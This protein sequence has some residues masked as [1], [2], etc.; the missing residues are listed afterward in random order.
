MSNERL[1]DLLVFGATGF[2]G[3]LTAEYLTRHVGDDIRWAIAGRDEHRLAHIKQE[4]VALN[5]AC[6]AVGIIVADAHDQ[7]S[8][9]EMVEQTKVVL[10]TVGPFAK[11]GELLVQACVRRGT[12]Y[13]DITGEPEFVHRIVER[14]DQQAREKGVRIVPCCGFDSIPHDLGVLFT[15]AQLPDNEPI[16]VEG[17]VS[18]SGNLS[19]G[20]WHSAVEAMAQTSWRATQGDLLPSDPSLTKKRKVR[21]LPAA[22][23]RE[24]LV[25]GWVCSLPTI[26]PKIVLR[27]AVLRADYGPD[28]QYGHYA[29]VQ[30][31]PK[32][33]GGLTAVGGIFALSKLGPTRKLLLNFRQPGQ[34]PDEAERE[35]G[36]FRV[37]FVGR[38]ASVLL[39]TE[40]RGG[41]PGYGETSKMVA[42]AALCLVQ[43]RADLPEQAGVLTTAVAM[44]DLLI[45]RLRRAGIEFNLLEDRV[46]A[47]QQRETS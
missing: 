33:V 29:R 39:K 31:L 12:D 35:E 37:T 16:V 44:G 11:Y 34:G 5:P 32:L 1:Y 14:Y 28:F 9:L 18:G 45:Q 15:V 46:F 19:G 20:T 40:V 13:V 23:R 41:D 27:T 2:T 38:T 7:L 30:S 42:E 8:L 36:R 21:E 4:L 26:D 17:F 43:D 6:T 3:K 47:P 24:P 10:T 25:D 22:I